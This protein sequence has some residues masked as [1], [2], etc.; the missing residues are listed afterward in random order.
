MRYSQVAPIPF[1]FP[2]ID[3][4]EL[5]N[6]TGEHLNMC[7]SNLCIPAQVRGMYIRNGN[8]TMT[9]NTA[10]NCEKVA[11]DKCRLVT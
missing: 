6:A 7:L 1:T 3:K 9:S 4:I 11:F 10:I 2:M 5:Y 8:L